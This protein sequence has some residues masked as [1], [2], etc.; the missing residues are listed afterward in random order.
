MQKDKRKWFNPVITRIMIALVSG[1]A[2]FLFGKSTMKSQIVRDQRALAY[3]QI[4]NNRAIMRSY[5]NLQKIE[6]KKV[7][8]GK[9]I[10]YLESEEYVKAKAFFISAQYRALIFGGKDL[11]EVLAEYRETMKSDKNS[12]VSVRLFQ[13]MRHDLL[14]GGEQVEDETIMR[15]LNPINSK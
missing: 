10:N 12:A 13:E 15:V 9:K 2:S 8:E 11:V 7:K 1:Y 4:V 3:V 5:Q 14:A 6:D